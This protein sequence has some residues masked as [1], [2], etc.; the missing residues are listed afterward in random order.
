VDLH[1]FSSKRIFTSFSL[2]D[3][4]FSSFSGFTLCLLKE[5]FHG[6]CPK[7]LYIFIPQQICT[8]SLQRQLSRILPSVA[9]YFHPLE[10]FYRISLE[11][12]ITDFSLSG[13]IFSS[14]RGFIPCFLRENFHGFCPQWLSFHFTTQWNYIVSAQRELS[15]ILP[16]VA[17][18]FHPSQDL[19]HVSLERIFMD[20]ALSGLLFSSP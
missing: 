6:F 20:F 18:Y 17:L 15:R 1:R 4:V 5:N 3:F 11:G 2:N 16:S 12:T 13:F 9:L 7:W 14:L 19:Y 8:M 10:D